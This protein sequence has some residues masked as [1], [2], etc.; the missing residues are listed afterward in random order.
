MG[1]CM[2]PRCLN[3]LFREIGNSAAGFRFREVY[4]MQLT[5]GNGRND[6]SL[7][8]GSAPGARDQDIPRLCV[9]GYTIRV[10]G[11]VMTGI[12]SLQ[13]DFFFFG[14]G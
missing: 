4:M 13:L 10:H 5:L 8:Q 12:G 14:S 1:R 9:K 2:V 11:A 6:W 3:P 7:S